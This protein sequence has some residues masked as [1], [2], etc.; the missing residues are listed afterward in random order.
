MTYP[1]LDVHLVAIQ[2]ADAD[3]F[4][5]WMTGAEEPL[6][7]A[8]RGFATSVDVEAVVQ[9]TLLR[10]WQLAP[11]FKP[12]GRA[13]SLLRFAHR[14]ARNL[15]LSEC[16]RLRTTH[17]EHALDELEA[18]VVVPPDPM[19]RRH[20]EA[21]REELPPRPA[22]ALAQRIH[23]SGESDVTLAQ[24][25]GMTVNTFLQNFSR[26]R[27]LLAECLARRG[28]DLAALGGGR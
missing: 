5:A 6:R 7:L 4:A 27:K 12:D 23:G 2:A 8:L 16:R 18:P 22:Q 21:C 17:D 19:L 20:I 9:E 13:N 15:A 10:V 3:A 24:R 1:D 26:A 28:V 25:V 11:A 14:V